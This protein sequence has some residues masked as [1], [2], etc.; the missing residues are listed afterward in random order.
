MYLVKIYV[1]LFNFFNL[2]VEFFNLFNLIILN[3]RDNAGL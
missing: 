1:T 2:N 3:R